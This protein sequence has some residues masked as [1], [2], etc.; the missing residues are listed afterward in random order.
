MPLAR[1][2]IGRIPALLARP[3]SSVPKEGSV[4]NL[5]RASNGPLASSAQQLHVTH[6]ELLCVSGR[7][8][9]WRGGTGADVRRDAHR[10]LPVDGEA[11]R[12]GGEHGENLTYLNVRWNI[13]CVH[14]GKKKLAQ[15]W[16]D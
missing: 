11:E 15:T 14:L 10:Q 2:L 1:Q 9:G 4:A 13:L 12:R 8:G 7:V 16:N 3:S 6:P 5:V